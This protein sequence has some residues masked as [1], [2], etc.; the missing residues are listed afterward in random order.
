MA[1][2]EKN[3][4]PLVSILIAALTAGIAS[5]FNWFS[6]ID[7]A[8]Y[9]FL[10]RQQLLS[11]SDDLVVVAVDEA[12]IERLGA[13]PWDRRYHARLLSQLS[14]A[15]A[16]VFDFIFAEAQSSLLGIAD[17]QVSASANRQADADQQFA[18]AM[19]D[20]A[21][22][23]LPVYVQQ[24][25]LRDQLSEVLP[26]PPFSEAAAALGHA[27][28]DYSE[29]GIARGVYLKEGL[30]GPF[31]PHLSLALAQFLG[32]ASAS[33]AGERDTGGGDFSQLEI[34]RDYFNLL[35]FIGP[36]NTVHRVSYTDVLD[37]VYPL[38]YWQG[39]R[40][41]VG[42]TATGLGDDIPTPVGA[43]PGVE[44]HAN[45]Y[46]AARLNHYI[47]RPN[48]SVHLGVSVFIVLVF[49]SLLSR[50][51]PIQFLISTFALVVFT[52]LSAYLLLAFADYWFSPIAVGIAIV[53]F[54]PLWSWRRI[55]IAL[56][57]LQQELALLQRES[58]V[59]D[60][61][62]A[63]LTNSL[64]GLMEIGVIKSWRL[65]SLDNAT[66]ALRQRL[67]SSAQV[68]STA[69]FKVDNEEYFIELEN[70]DEGHDLTP[71]VHAL[72]S[73]SVQDLVSPVSSYELVEK[74]IREIY[75][76]KEV[77]EKAQLRMNKSMAELQDAVLVADAAGKIIFTNENF[78]EVFGDTY[79][80]QSLVSLQEKISGYVWLGILR[81][82][83][84]EDERVYQE[85][86]LSDDRELL[87]Q[88]ALIT[89]QANS[90]DTLVFVFTDVTQLRYL[91]RGKNE[92]LA[93]LSHDMRSPIVSLLSLIETYRI[94]NVK[95]DDAT[96]ELVGQLEFFARKNLKYSEDFLQLSR[97]ENIDREVFQLVDMHGVVDGAYAQ[98]FGF[99]KNK[100]VDVII[101]RTQDDCWVSG[102]VQLLERAVTN[103]L[104]N[105]IQHTPP[106]KQVRLILQLMQGVQIVIQDQGG[107]IA[108]E[109]IP[110]LFEPYFRARDKKQRSGAMVSPERLNDRQGANSGPGNGPN[111]G[112]RS[113][114]LGLS[115][116][117]TVV[118]RHGGSIHVD[119]EIGKSSSFTLKFPE[120]AAE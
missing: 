81:T 99:S 24:V 30:G 58:K 117:H 105:A 61:D 73:S 69:V 108:E 37:G 32:E 67:A 9:D 91:E 26:I 5:L 85:L 115:F 68:D 96:R 66:E 12:S 89:D 79:I 92:A 49:A 21:R 62:F 8:Y 25:H 39:K 22:V 14:E 77:A 53:L 106:G 83:M 42:A 70:A 41:F 38:T 46:H 51:T 109:M 114:G 63:A 95:L 19:A 107:G 54:Y 35:R 82:L 31:W 55:E 59:S 33:L 50:L 116:V 11:W 78:R 28:V 111:Q 88:G 87:C 102:D 29:N 27:H 90:Q 113:Y 17:E 98:V 94:N 57:F 84:L 45:A 43:L 118:K 1:R 23:L 36:P 16:V 74:T 103:I 47:S 64:N 101:E 72:L 110:H 40:V 44:F 34:Y 18:Q 119:S 100:N 120:T 60:F 80:E 15:D 10:L 3:S 86:K 93:F 56:S 97:A 52:A 4:S 2:S 71:V 65:D 13:W 112:A 7:T 48:T 104:Y 75:S 6:S 20:H 76:I